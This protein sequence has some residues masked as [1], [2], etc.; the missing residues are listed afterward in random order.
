VAEFL[1][2][3]STVSRLMRNDR[4]AVTA[5]RRSGARAV[6]ISAVT[7]SELLYGA[8]L[9]SAPD[10]MAKVRRFLSRIVIHPWDAEAAEQHSSIRTTTRN[11]GRSAGVYDLMIV[12]HAASLGHILVTSDKALAKLRVDGLRVVEW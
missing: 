10:P 8:R 5:M 4:E 12:A 2:D 3:T 9:S 7:H 11:G 6:G 1:L